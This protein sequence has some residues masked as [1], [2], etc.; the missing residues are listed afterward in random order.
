MAELADWGDRMFDFRFREET[1]GVCTVILDYFSEIP[2]PSEDESSYF[3]RSI[4]K[5]TSAKMLELP[6]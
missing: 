3:L 6:P 2:S 4:S 5:S 1:Y